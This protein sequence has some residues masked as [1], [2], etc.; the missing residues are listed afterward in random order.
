[1]FIVGF[2]LTSILGLWKSKFDSLL[3]IS[4]LMVSFL[5]NLSSIDTILQLVMLTRF[6]YYLY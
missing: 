1:M 2:L 4:I 3:F 6:K 5:F